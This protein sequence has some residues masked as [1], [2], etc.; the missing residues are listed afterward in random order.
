MQ[1]N[2]HAIRGYSYTTYQTPM[3]A[4]ISLPAAPKTLRMPCKAS[5][6]ISAPLQ[7]PLNPKP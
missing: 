7:H 5:G 2:K 1:N 3:H 6:I 4:T